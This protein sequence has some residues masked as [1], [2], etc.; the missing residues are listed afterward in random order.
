MIKRMLSLKPEDR[1]EA[2]AV[3]KELE[4]NLSCERMTV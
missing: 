3:K 2:E 4:H 1:P